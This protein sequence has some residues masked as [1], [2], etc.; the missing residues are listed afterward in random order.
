M[1]KIVLSLILV[2]GLLALGVGSAQAIELDFDMA[3]PT[4]G[5]ISYAGGA[6]SLVGAGIQVDTVTGLDTPSNQGVVLTVYG[7]L[8]NFTSGGQAGSTASQWKFGAGGV[9]SITITGALDLVGGDGIPDTGNITLMHG[10]ITSASVTY[11]GGT[12]HVAIVT[13][14]D[15]KAYDLVHYFGY[16]GTTNWFGGLNLSFNAAA[17]APPSGFASTSVLSGDVVNTPLPPTALL[18]GAGLLGLAVLG[19]RRKNR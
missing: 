17:V 5:T 1:K 8:L 9:D 12:F 10:Q 11:T 14:N 13:Y 18:L 4:S 15:E 3:A 6:A 2:G 7:G 19:R 16:D